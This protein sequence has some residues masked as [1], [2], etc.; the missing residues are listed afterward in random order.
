M[1]SSPCVRTIIICPLIIQENPPTGTRLNSES[2]DIKSLHGYPDEQ[3]DVT[4]EC[5]ILEKV[6]SRFPN[7]NS[8]DFSVHSKWVGAKE[9]L[10]RLGQIPAERHVTHDLN[11]YLPLLVPLFF[12]P[13]HRIKRL[14]IA[15]DWQ[16]HYG[17]TPSPVSG[18]T[19]QPWKIFN[20]LPGL[21]GEILYRAFRRAAQPNTLHWLLEL[22]SST[23]SGLKTT[24]IRME[25]RRQLPCISC[26]QLHLN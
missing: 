8:L 23:V 24:F 14:R 18:R 26:S 9:L 10:T 25:A 19:Y 22:R 13:D 7:L 20:P 21:D 6:V 4:A 2:A 5:N 3:E 16:A 17:T 11:L 12:Q 15:P 1:N